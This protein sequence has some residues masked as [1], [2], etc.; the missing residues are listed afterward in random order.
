MDADAFRWLLTDEGTRL[1]AEAAAALEDGANELTVQARLR[2]RADGDLVT[3]ALTQASLRR[4]ARAKFGEAADLLWFTP[5]GLEQATRP[6]VAAHRARRLA[7]YGVDAFADL[8]C[9]I[10]GD[11]MAVATATGATCVGTDLDPVTA[12]VAR[13]NVASLGL[14]VAVDVRD[15][16][17]LDLAPFDA[18][19]ID[20]ARRD[21]TGRTFRADAWEPSWDVVTGLLTGPVPAVAKVAPGLPHDLVPEGVEAEWVSDRGHLK[22]AALWGPALATASRRATVLGATG[23]ATLTDEDDPVGDRVP[24]P[25]GA[26]GDYLVEPDD[27]VVRAGLVTA[28]AA[29]CDGWLVDPHLAYVSAHAPGPAALSRSYRVL[30]ELPYRE[31]QLRAALRFRRIGALTIKK[32]GVD[33][34]PAQLRKRLDL[35]GDVTATLVLTRVAGA[36]TA[37]LVEPV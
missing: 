25:T 33:V 10:G 34:V 16:T 37:L 3:A 26:V 32:R 36:G 27:A 20:P 14:P 11:L 35:S 22:E 12:A 28:V 13:A 1:V 23:L 5:A 29:R 19:M 18:A 9:G 31:K 7:A 17:T 21:G 8:T 15:G 4:R 30:E 2:R 24:A 6:A